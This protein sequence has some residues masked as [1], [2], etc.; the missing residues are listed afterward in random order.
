L[1]VSRQFVAFV[2]RQRDRLERCCRLGQGDVRT[3]VRFPTY[4]LFSSDGASGPRH[5]DQQIAAAPG[6]AGETL[7][8]ADAAHLLAI[9]LERRVPRERDAHLQIARRRMIEAAKSGAFTI[10]AGSRLWPVV[11]WFPLPPE[12]VQGLDAESIDW[13]NS[14]FDASSGAPMAATP[15]VQGLHAGPSTLL[16]ALGSF[17]EAF[18]I[19]D[20]T[21]RRWNGI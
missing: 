5:T 12:C 20:Q 13:E 10:V 4:A 18:G 11:T 6:P 15:T 14:A 19:D 7:L 17:V 2:S 3:M 9:H 1:S 16:V 21:L 8:L